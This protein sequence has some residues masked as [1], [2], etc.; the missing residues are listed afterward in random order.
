MNDNRYVVYKGQ[1]ID[2]ETFEIIDT[3]AI[4]KAKEKQL[5]QEYDKLTNELNEIGEVSTIKMVKDKKGN[6]HSV[7]NVKEGFHFVKVFKVDIRNIIETCNLS[8]VARGFLYTCLAYLYFPTNTLVIDGESPS[9]EV[10]CEK[11]G[12]GKTKLYAVYKELE[13][14]DIIKRKK[15]NGQMVIYLNPYLHSVGFVDI[16][17][18]KMFNDSEFNPNR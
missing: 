5:K 1:L 13:K 9:N 10:I 8:I 18:C 6:E 7:L 15:F 16:E 3:H 4:R 14:L 2:I 17:T 12:I 11:F